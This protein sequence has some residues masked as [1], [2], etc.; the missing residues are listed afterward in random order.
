MSL[1]PRLLLWASELLAAGGR[2]E[3]PGE[4][5]PCVSGR[6]WSAAGV[7]WGCCSWP[8][9]GACPLGAGLGGR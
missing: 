8:R 2:A 9:S 7:G 3:A 6:S 5:A 1:A 4:G